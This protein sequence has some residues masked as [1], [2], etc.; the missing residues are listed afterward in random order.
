M[1]PGMKVEIIAVPYDSGHGNRRMG[2]GPDH[3]LGSGLAD[4]LRAGG[5][6]VEVSRVS[7]NSDFP[8]E[9]GTSFELYRALAGKVRAARQEGRFPLVLSGNCGSSLGTLAG[10]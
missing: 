3:L 1:E 6:E 7:S 10:L 2:R 8:T 9:V 5:H 4:A